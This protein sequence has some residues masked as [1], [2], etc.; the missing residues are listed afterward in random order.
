MGFTPRPSLAGELLGAGME[1]YQV[2]DGRKV[3]SVMTAVGSGYTVGR[4]I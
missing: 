3:G 4:S 1:V 2:G